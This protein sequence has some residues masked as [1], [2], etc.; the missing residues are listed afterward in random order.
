[1]GSKYLSAGLATADE[2]HDARLMLLRKW[3]AENHE[4]E[5]CV[6]L[7]CDLNRRTGTAQTA[8]HK[9]VL[10]ND[11]STLRTYLGL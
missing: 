9:L 7:R 10:Y 6:T 3:T 2:N 1:M 5:C 4:D 11:Q 8:Q